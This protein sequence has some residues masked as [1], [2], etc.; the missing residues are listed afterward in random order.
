M[1]GGV[2]VL[3]G[4]WGMYAWVGKYMY[5]MMGRWLGDVCMGGRVYVLEGL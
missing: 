4:G 2:C 1:G 5:W 3:M